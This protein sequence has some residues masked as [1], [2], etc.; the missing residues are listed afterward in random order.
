[1]QK[2]IKELGA[3][4]LLSGIRSKQTE[5]RKHID[6][7]EEPTDDTNCYRL[8]PLLHWNTEDIDRYFREHN[9]PRH[10][11][12]SQGYVSV[13]DA[14]S[15]RP[16]N[17]NDSTDRETRFN[18]RPQ[19]ECG[20]HTERESEEY[21]TSLMS[22]FRSSGSISTCSENAQCTTPAEGMCGGPERDIS[23]F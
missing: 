13:G 23:P 16:K 2:A 4:C 7:F 9:L 8:Y 20:L 19:Q 15:S 5:H 17:S 18:G 21:Y 10:P 1:M 11:L 14:H 6:P 3:R 22:M 12:E